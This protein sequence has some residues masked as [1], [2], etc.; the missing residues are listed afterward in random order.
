MSDRCDKHP[1]WLKADCAHCNP[2]LTDYQRGKAAALRE[3][4]EGEVDSVAM[5]LFRE[6]SDWYGS[7]YGAR[8]D[9]RVAIQTFIKLRQEG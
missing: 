1:N 5:T 2:P 9:A 6:N 7:A 8:D 4:S 3:P